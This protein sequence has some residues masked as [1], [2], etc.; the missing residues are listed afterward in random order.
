MYEDKKFHLQFV[1]NAVINLENS[2]K[3]YH[4]DRY[5]HFYCT[6]NSYCVKLGLSFEKFLGK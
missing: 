6:T 4:S 1:S 2:A 5:T 3:Y